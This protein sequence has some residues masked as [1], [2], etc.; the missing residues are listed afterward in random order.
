VPRATCSS[1]RCATDPDRHPSRRVDAP[2]G[3]RNHDQSEK[4]NGE[5][6][7]DMTIRAGIDGFGRSGTLTIEYINGRS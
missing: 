6:I 7:K 3:Q 5:E 1:G 2:R 4:D